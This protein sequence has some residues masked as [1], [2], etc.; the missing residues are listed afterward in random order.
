MRRSVVLRVL[1]KP[2]AHC[3]LIEIGYKYAEKPDKL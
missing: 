1:Q 2:N 3:A